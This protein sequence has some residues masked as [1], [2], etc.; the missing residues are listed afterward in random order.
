MSVLSLS[1]TIV[2]VY[3]VVTTQDIY[4]ANYETYHL[5]YS[6]VKC[7]IRQLDINYE[8]IIDGK[9]MNVSQ[10]RIYIPSQLSIVNT[11][12]IIDTVRSRKYD[13]VYVNRM[14]R[15]KHLEIDAKRVETILGTF[16][17]Y[18]SSSDS[19]SSEDYSSSSSFECPN[20]ITGWNGSVFPI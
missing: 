1:N 11:D 10:Y 12:L 20:I 8:A 7:R 17:L 3:S 16:Q 18:S 5:K 6:N 15:K 14:D 19:S 4:G 2:N 9:E 13:V